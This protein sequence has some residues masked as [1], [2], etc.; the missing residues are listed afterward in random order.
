MINNFQIQ[1]MQG[2]T[3]A[4]MERMFQDLRSEISRSNQVVS[5]D[6]DT[7][8]EEDNVSNGFGVF[9][10]G[11]R[12][13]PVPEGWI[14]PSVSTL[15]L[16]QLWFHGDT[17][18]NIRPYKFIKKFDVTKNKGIIAK[19]RGVINAIISCSNDTRNPTELSVADSLHIYTIGYR[20]LI[21]RMVTINPRLERRRHS[22]LLFTSLYNTLK[23][24]KLEF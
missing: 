5:N 9:T 8:Q 3:P 11:N 12:I 10:W 7:V 6:V 13:H 18:A 24:M 21:S 22:E 1:G 23:E 20:Q 16:W 15:N 19:A 4:L 2:I 14:F 17:T